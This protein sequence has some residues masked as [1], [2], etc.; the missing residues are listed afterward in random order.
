MGIIA[1]INTW[2][3][4]ISLMYS[5]LLWY[6]T[7]SPGNPTTRLINGILGLQ[8]NEIQL[9]RLVQGFCFL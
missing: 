2:V 9:Y 7:L 6:E 3:I 1:S 8:G 4:D 5:V